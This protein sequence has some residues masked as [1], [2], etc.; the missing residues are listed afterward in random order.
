MTLSPTTKD[1]IFNIITSNDFDFVEYGSVG[2]HFLNRIWDLKS[3]PSSDPRFKNAEGDIYQ[4]MINNSDWDL[5]Y[6]FRERLNLLSDDEKFIKF[7]EAFVLP[8]YRKDDDDGYLIII[9]LNSILENDK[10]QFSIDDY[11]EKGQPIYKIFDK[12]LV[13]D[14]PS[15][16]MQN[17]IPFIV[18]RHD[19]NT[20]TALT[21]LEETEPREY[22]T[23]KESRWDDFYSKT[24]FDLN[25]YNGGNWNGIGQVKIMVKAQDAH[26]TAEVLPSIFYNLSRD[27]CSLG[28]REHFYSTLKEIFAHR[29]ED[30]LFAI[31]DCA[32]FSD[33]LEEFEDS[34]RFKNSLIR[35]DYAERTLRII[36]HK[37]S[38]SNLEQPFKF[39]YNFTP[40]YS[41]ESISVPFEFKGEENEILSNRIY[42][43]IGKNGTGKTQLLTSLPVNISEGKSE[44]F[45]PQIPLFSKMITVSYSIFD[46]FK[47]PK[48]T[49]K[50]NYVYC[51]LKNEK[52][53]FITEKGLLLRFHH[54]WKKINALER[55]NKWRAVLAN[56]IEDDILNEFLILK[57]NHSPHVPNAYEVNLEG[58]NRIKNQLSS[59]QNILLYIITEITANIRYDSLLLY[60][61]PETHLHPNAISELVNT[62]Y[63]LVSEF[64]SFCV[65][66]TH[67]PIIIQELLSKNVFVLERDGDSPS[68]RRISIES[69]GENLAI[70]T[71]DVFGNREV[72]KQYKKIIDELAR[73]GQTF[74]Q[75]LDAFTFDDR[76]LSLNTRLYIKSKTR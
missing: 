53:E 65:I 22:F 59:G 8:E 27:F 76:P 58:F 49:S 7:I 63:E 41:D 24:T 14:I 52:G 2:F 55:M 36:R 5:N 3:M 60:D 18:I 13:Q 42:A 31:A 17:R 29:F 70:L 45:E 50:F 37:L 71:D 26:E 57:P 43:I 68:I 30:I 9:S 21:R 32:F 11:N 51:G 15:D 6:L 12:V 54:T 39:T 64:Q 34:E 61:E 38:N 23:L 75:I 10:L 72:P 48:K 66:G 56:F 69:F 67:S 19:E 28:Q 46:R 4:H 25:Y 74:D 35:N 20:S 40:K 1:E 16:I 33:R 44:F 62:I 47:I 73:D